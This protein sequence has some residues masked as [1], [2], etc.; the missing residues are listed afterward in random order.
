MG[1]LHP[2]K[3]STSSNKCEVHCEHD[4]HG[5]PIINPISSAQP[6]NGIDPIITFGY[7]P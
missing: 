2:L 1:H 7:N 4:K 3:N 5:L 6:N